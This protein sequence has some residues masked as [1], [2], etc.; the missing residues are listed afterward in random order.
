MSRIDVLG[1]QIRVTAGLADVSV[2]DFHR[3]LRVGTIV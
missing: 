3:F 2:D 1:C